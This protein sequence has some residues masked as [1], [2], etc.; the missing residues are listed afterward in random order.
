MNSTDV[1]PLRTA[2][3]VAHQLSLKVTTVY[4]AV[5]AGRLPCVKLWKG[6]RRAL[7]RFRQSDVDALIRGATVAPTESPR[8]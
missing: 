2:Q 5:A 3:Q 4:A 7:I 1:A 6:R 8:D